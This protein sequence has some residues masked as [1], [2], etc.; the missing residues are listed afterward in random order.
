M[1]KIMMINTGGTFSAV[2]GELGLAPGLTGEDIAAILGFG[3]DVMLMPEDYCSLDSANIIPDDWAEI[4]RRVEK[5]V[6]KYD[7]VII[8]HGTD[9]MAYTASMLSFMIQNVPIPVV[10]T[11]SQLPLNDPLTDAADNCRCAVRMACTGVG[12][13]YV[14]FNRKVILGCRSSKVRTVSFDAFES[15]N[16][17]LVGEFNAFGMQLQR[18]LLPPQNRGLC[19][20]TGYSD[21]IAVLKV[22]PGMKPDIFSYLQEKGYEGIFIEGFGLGG[23]PFM[24]NNLLKEIE[25]ASAAGIPILVGS[26]CR[27]E[28]SNL[29]I[30]ETGFRV[31]ACG[32]I[33]VYDMTQ[34][35][36]VTKLMWCLG[37]TKD[38]SEIQRMLLTN[39]V[40]EIRPE[41]DKPALAAE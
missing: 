7:G 16:Y 35:A 29:N 21:K 24:R 22:F 11:G 27:Y 32:G 6:G 31:Q 13:V 4:A 23:V 2:E 18:E 15:I 5:A 17:P 8:I 9:V 10:L 40:N 20:R 36:T 30:Y 26:Q 38:R 19:L 25:K 39:M 33:P 3:E 28:G 41:P 14:V 34:E 37:Q 1:K 12:G